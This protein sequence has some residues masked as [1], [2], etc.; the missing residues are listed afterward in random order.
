[1]IGIFLFRRSVTFSHKNMVKDIV[2]QFKLF[3][4]Q[5]GWIQ[6]EIA[7]KLECSRS[8]VSKIFS[9]TRNPSIKLLEKMEEVMKNG[10]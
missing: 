9:E 3:C 5:K 2:K 7:N 10:K 6:E 8:H 1:M 4:H